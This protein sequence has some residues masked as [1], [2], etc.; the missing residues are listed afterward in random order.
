MT[1]LQEPI[2]RI[3]GPDVTDHVAAQYVQIMK[4]AYNWALW[5][6][7]FMVHEGSA[8]DMKDDRKRPRAS[9]DDCP[10]NC[11][12]AVT[13]CN[14]CVSNQIPGNAGLGM[15]GSKWARTAGRL[16]GGDSDEDFAAY[17]FGSLLMRKFYYDS[18]AG[19]F[20]KPADWRPAGDPTDPGD[21]KKVMCDL[22]GS[23]VKKN[24]DKEFV[25]RQNIEEHWCEP[26][27]KSVGKRLDRP[28][29][30]VNYPRN[31]WNW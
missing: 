22:L 26:C 7:P 16:Q 20:R 12:W 6:S 2:K 23:L 29:P 1:L 31:G 3:C 25:Q 21:V 9:V 10:T 19:K 15:Y 18:H 11:W 5:S 17:G 24:T 4:S 27:T 8:I 30:A 13:L 14:K 28:S